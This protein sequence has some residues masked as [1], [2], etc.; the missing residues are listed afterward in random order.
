MATLKGST[1]ASTYDLLLKR[2]ETYSQTGTNV[3]LMDDSGDVQ[4]TGLYLESGATTDNVGIGVADPD[5]LLELYKVGTQLKLSGGAADYATFAVAADGALTITTVDADAAEADIILA[6]DG[7]VGI[8]TAAPDEP[9]DVL[10]SGTNFH[11]IRLTTSKSN[12]TDQRV[13]INVQHYTSA[14]EPITL[15]GSRVTSTVAEGYIGGGFST[16]NAVKSINF[17]TAADNTT[18][19]GTQRM[20]IDEN[21]NVGI[22][23]TTPDARL[24]VEDTSITTGSAH[25]FGIYGSHTIDDGTNGYQG[26]G[27]LSEITYNDSG[28][29]FSNLVGALIT[30]TA[31]AAN[32]AG[33]AVYGT[34]ISASMAGSNTNVNNVYGSNVL[35]DVDAGTVDN[36]VYG[37]KVEVDIESGVTAISGNVYGQYTKVDDAQGAAGTV[38]GQYIDCDTGV[39]VGLHVDGAGIVEEGGVL[40]ENLLTNSGFDVWSNSTLENVGSDRVTNGAFGAD[41]LKEFY[42]K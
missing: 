14:E 3:E 35:A 33:T 41:M 11:N 24:K 7:N 19:T 28:N 16:Q 42:E 15:I 13:G 18:V 20:I 8:G 29:Y 34:N 26:I 36:D 37:Q 17:Y 6:P 31:T 22:G 32:G 40:K 38:Y 12:S 21:G 1:I 9:L 30:A 27:L 23:D 25:Y 10:Y 4:V 2:N 39:D 5:E